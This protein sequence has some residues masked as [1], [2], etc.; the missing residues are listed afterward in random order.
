MISTYH[1]ETDPHEQT[2]ATAKN[3]SESSWHGVNTGFPYEIAGVSGNLPHGPKAYLLIP[4]PTNDK[5]DYLQ[6]CL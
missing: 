6:H 1:L 3:S 5:P 2:C 4:I